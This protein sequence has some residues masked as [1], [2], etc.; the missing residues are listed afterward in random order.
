MTNNDR[1]A[2]EVS[3]HELLMNLIAPFILFISSDP[4]LFL[5]WHHEIM[6]ATV[7]LWLL[8]LWSELF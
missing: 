8:L 4:L 3:L 5:I 6:I 1:V 2:S 7:R